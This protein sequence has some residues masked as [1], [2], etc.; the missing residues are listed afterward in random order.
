LYRPIHLRTYYFLKEKNNCDGLGDDGTF[1]S[2]LI[3]TPS[4]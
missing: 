3:A 4:G 2:N 1:T